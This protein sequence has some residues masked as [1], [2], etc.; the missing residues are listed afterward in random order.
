MNSNQTALASW[1]YSTEEWNRFVDIEQKNKREDS[2]YLGIGVLI[3]GTVGLL[4]I[5]HMT[6]FR[7][8]DSQ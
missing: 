7:T 6:Y 8:P 4:R 3:L 1:R 5:R 2:M